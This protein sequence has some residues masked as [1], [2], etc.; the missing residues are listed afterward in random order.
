MRRW[1]VRGLLL[2][3]AVLALPVAQAQP[4]P[5]LLPLSPL[6]REYLVA[7]PTIVVGQYDSGWPPFES[8]RDGEQVGLG[9]DYLS[10]LA[11]QLGVKVEARRYPDWTSVL[12]A[13]CRGEIDVVMNV[14]LSAD[15]TRCMVYTAAYSEAPLALVG[16]PDD[17]RASDMPDLDG[18]RVV[19]EQDFL[20]GPQVRARFPRARQLVANDTL[21]ALQMVIDD[22]ADVYIGNAFV[23]TELIASRRL[24]GVALLRPSDLPPNGCTSAFPT[25]SNPW[26]KPW[27]W[28]WPRP[29]RP[30]A[31]PSHN[32]GCHRRTGR[33]RRSWR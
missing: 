31:M 22:K 29:A 3:L 27:T 2:L 14:G 26:P 19:I 25:A 10:H 12:D 1:A 8:L 18:L 21:S 28:R 11:R 15:R 9:P 4:A 7:H 33:H 17:L 24:Q 13:A 30:S 32:A 6:Q 5:G 20:T 23:A 16:R